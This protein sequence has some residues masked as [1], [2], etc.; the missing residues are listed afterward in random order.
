MCELIAH[1]GAAREHLENTLPAFQRALDLGADG[2]ELDVHCTADGTVVVQHDAVPR[3]TPT[4][5]ALAGRPIATLTT[6]ELASFRF[7]DGTAV[8]TLD[9]VVQMLRARAILYCELKGAGTA[10]PALMVLRRYGGPSAVHSFDHR[11]VADA[12]AYAPEIPRGVLEVSRHVDPAESLRAVDARDLWQ[13]AEYVDEPLVRAAHAAGRRVIAWTANTAEAIERLAAC[14]VDG[15]C[16][17]DVPLARRVL[18]R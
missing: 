15:L 7:P 8:P 4:D 12:A 3:G 5:A 9:D 18:G 6:A 11:M 16:T 10:L 17:D 1:R 2:V 14:G 13:L